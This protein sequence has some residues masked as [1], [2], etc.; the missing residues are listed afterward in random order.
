MARQRWLPFALT[1]LLTGSALALYACATAGTQPPIDTSSTAIP[2]EDTTG[3]DG[4]LL[5]AGEDAPL[6]LASCFGDDAGCD[7]L[8]LCGAQNFVKEVAQAA[9]TAAG[10]TVVP[11]VY[12]MTSYTI[13]TG[14]SGGS[15]TLTNWFKETFQLSAPSS[16]DGGSDDGGLVALT[17]LDV[18]ETDQS[19]GTPSHG[20]GQAIVQGTSMN[21]EHSC[22]SASS[23]PT[24]YT[25]TANTIT[26]YFADPG[27]GTAENVFTLMTQ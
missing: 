9:P 8:A 18:S 16:G 27:T 17:W 15:E 13:Y 11:G 21:L 26:I 5:D 1:T 22:P 20:S 25:A 24:T 6:T 10:G 7:N 19:G 23:F 12:S 14:T 2:H 4:G 3:G